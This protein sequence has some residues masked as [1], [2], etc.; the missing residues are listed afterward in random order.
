MPGTDVC[1]SDCAS[2]TR[3]WSAVHDS[4]TAV[5]LIH[6]GLRKNQATLTTAEQQAFVN[7][8]I[9]LKQ[10]PSR[11]HPG[12]NA[13][14]RYDDF[15]EVHLN[16]M[17]VMMN[18]PAAVSWG[19]MAAAFGPWHRVLLLEFERELQAI[20]PS[21]TLPYWDL[22]KD[23][24][25]TS[26]LWS[27]DFLGGNGSGTDKRVSDGPFAG[28]TGQWPIRLKDSANDADFLRRDIAASPD[29]QTL[30]THHA[31]TAPHPHAHHHVHPHALPMFALP[32]EIPALNKP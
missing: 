8:L 9:A 29:A 4:R 10:K 28:A 25:K 31:A 22:T 23:R 12:S 27:S 3:Q 19:H 26:S 21:V 20:N 32:A 1:P 16:A 11:L 7:A 5:R 14:S 24:K 13:H 6:I 18:T 30:P 15:V 17:L 2:A